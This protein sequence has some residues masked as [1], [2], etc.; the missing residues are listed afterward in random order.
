MG[1]DTFQLFSSLPSFGEGMARVLD[2]NGSL[3]DHGYIL[4]ET[5][6]EADARALASDWSATM[7]D[8]NAATESA[9]G[10]KQG[11]EG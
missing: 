7:N 10:S 5:P 4:S 8:I 11:K 9:I 6:R 2:L 1:R 3:T